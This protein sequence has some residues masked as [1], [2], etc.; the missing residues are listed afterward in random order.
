MKRIILAVT[1]FISAF[2][3]SACEHYFPFNNG[4]YGDEYGDH[5]G[6]YG[7]EHGGG[8]NNGHGGG[9]EGGEHDD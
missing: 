7:G 5:G 6:Y 8:Y 1:I 3:L 2:M 9:H 4:Y